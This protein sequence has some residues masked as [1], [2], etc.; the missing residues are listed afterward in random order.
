MKYKLK[1]SLSNI[2][3][4]VIYHKQITIFIS[5]LLLLSS[6]LAILWYFWDWINR[7]S[8]SLS[9][10]ATLITGLALAIFAWL[11]YGL[12]K[13]ITIYQ[14]TP[15]IQ[16]Y[17]VSH[18]ES[19]EIV[20]SDGCKYEGITWSINLFNVGEIPSVISDIEILM[21]PVSSRPFSFAVTRF[22][23]LFDENDNMVDPKRIT[24]IDGRS[25]VKFNVV[26]YDDTVLSQ[27]NL[28]KKLRYRMTVLVLQQR[29]QFLGCDS[30]TRLISQEVQFPEKSGRSIMPYFSVKMTD[31]K[32]LKYHQL[33]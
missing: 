23:V 8:S 22:C 1:D 11:T 24:I 26:L 14:F 17:S 31:N 29:K 16:L 33:K 15:Q 13:K 32:D 12:S 2:N 6:S 10:I 28:D 21:M 25:D 18:P 27:Y 5:I 7:N 9:F 30:Y 19:G 20:V 3:L 4:W